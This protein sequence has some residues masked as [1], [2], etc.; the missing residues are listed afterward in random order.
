MYKIKPNEAK[1]REKNKTHGVYKG[2]WNEDNTKLKVWFYDGCIATLSPQY[3]D[4]FP[5][6]FNWQRSK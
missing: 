1:F 2:A 5:E 6:N 3:L 4:A